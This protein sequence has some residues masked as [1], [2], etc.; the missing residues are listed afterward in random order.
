MDALLDAERSRI[1]LEDWSC[2]RM[3]MT[4]RVQSRIRDK[5]SSFSLVSG[6]ELMK[7]LQKRA[8][9]VHSCNTTKRK[10]GHKGKTEGKKNAGY[11]FCFLG[12]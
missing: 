3:I 7:L 5:N 12:K 8:N 9:S 1:M 6:K 4:L 11:F 2:H 10:P